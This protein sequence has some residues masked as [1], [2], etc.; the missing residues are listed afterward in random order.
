[1]AKK[2]RKLLVCYNEPIGMYDNYTGKTNLVK[3]EFNDLSESGFIEQINEIIASLKKYYT[4]VGH[5]A[6]TSDIRKTV[7][8]LF[9]SSPDIIFNFVE[10]INGNANYEPYISG[11]FEL[12]GFSFTGN[13]A[14]SLGNCLDKIRTKHILKS[15]NI[16]TPDFVLAK[17]KETF[18]EK[19]FLLRFPVII[20]LIKEDASIGISENSVVNDIYSLNKQLKFMYKTYKQDIIIE[21]FVKGREFNVSIL[22]DKILPISEITFK[23]L[24]KSLPNLVTYEAKWAPESDYYKSTIPNCPAKISSKLEKKLRQLALAS[25]KAMDCRDYARVDFRVDKHSNPYVIEVNPNPDISKDSG[26]IRSAKKAGISYSKVLKIIVEFAK[27][28]IDN[29]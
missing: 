15:S 19:S 26:F 22:G 1:M 7:K 20:K 18:S 4:N 6:V 10:S 28:R 17:L 27:E 21:E 23:N 13:S 9:K 11:L 25:Y 12:V 24:D 29:D 2:K 5:Y 8:D 3:K 14:L 16:A